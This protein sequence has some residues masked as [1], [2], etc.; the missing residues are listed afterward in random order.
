VNLHNLAVSA[1]SD[2][3]F[4]FLTLDKDILINCQKTTER[5]AFV[6]YIL[7]RSNVAPFLTRYS[8]AVGRPWHD[9][10]SV[11]LSVCNKCMVAKR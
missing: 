8:Y 7:D 5:I 2:T 3:N 6:L 11:C 4:V 10:S 1:N 9:V